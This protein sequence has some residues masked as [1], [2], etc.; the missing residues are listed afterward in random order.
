MDAYDQYLKKMALLDINAA[1]K[2]WG[3]LTKNALAYRLSSLGLEERAS[4]K[5]FF[6]RVSFRKNK[7]GKTVTVREQPLIPSLKVGYKQFYGQI[8][9]V[10]VSFARHGIFVEHGV[11]KGR[12]KGSAKAKPRPWLAPVMAVQVPILAD[13]LAK[14]EA[15]RVTGQL[16]FLVPGIIDIKVTVNP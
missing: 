11:G 14:R 12:P 3:G 15:D 4:E 8:D 7:A 5:K 9:R 2:N 1:I 6:S 13:V 16:R 10:T